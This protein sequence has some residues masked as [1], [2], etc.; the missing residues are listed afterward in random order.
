LGGCSSKEICK[1]ADLLDLSNESMSFI[2]GKEFLMGSYRDKFGDKPPKEVLVS[3]F[4]MDK[5][6]ITNGIYKEY[7]KS[8][9]CGAKKPP[10]L[11]DPIYGADELPVVGVTHNEAKE[12]CKFYNKRLPTEAEWEYAARGG[13]NIKKFPWGD[14]ESSDSMNYRGSNNSWAIA[15]MSYPPNAY[16]LYDMAGNVREWVVDTY[17]KD[18][19]KYS[20]L[21]SPLNL[22]LSRTITHGLEGIYKS[23]C[24][25]DPINRAEGRYKVNRGG[26]W[27]YSDGYPNSVYFRGF[28]LTSSRF[29]DLGFRCATNAEKE[30]WIVKKIK[31]FKEKLK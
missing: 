7:I 6:E 23:D 26:S 31:E 19:Y 18:F 22:N 24:Y 13:L 16:G 8:K 15:I 20:C 3:N 14:E 5:A 21:K 10:Y 12:F 28:D 4:Y 30:N 29:N 17:E 2:M 27:S 25:K 11:D 1:R 9:S